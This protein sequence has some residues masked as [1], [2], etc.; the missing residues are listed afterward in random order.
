MK[1]K[2]RIVLSVLVVLLLV[3]LLGSCSGDDV[4]ALGP[5]QSD[6]D[7]AQWVGTVT[8]TDLSY[9]GEPQVEV[10]FGDGYARSITVA[11]LGFPDCGGQGSVAEG[12]LRTRLAE[13][14]PAGVAVRVVRALSYG[15]LGSSGYVFTESSVAGP[16]S[17]EPMS[18][19]AVSTSSV[20]SSSSISPTAAPRERSSEEMLVPAGSATTTRSASVSSTTA[21]RASEPVS[22]SINEVLLSEGVAVVSPSVDLS[23][24]S[25]QPVDEQVETAMGFELE[26]NDAWFTYLVDASRSA[27]DASRGSQAACR[28]TDRPRVEEKARRDAEKARQEEAQARQDAIELEKYTEDA[29]RRQA[30]REQLDAV[31]AGAD[32]QL[33]TADDDNRESAFDGDGNL[34]L[35]PTPGYSSGGSGGGGGGFVC[36]RSRLC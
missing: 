24:A 23:I 32:G 28:N 30:Q 9:D 16:S 35:V 1:S 17:P 25:D 5:R 10:D 27:W 18:S 29:A 21:G 34:Y 7:S 31:R 19:T 3:G 4:T 36:R 22:G 12:V 33:Y 14:L 13:L 20:A 6:P 15:S 26:G 8:G 2:G 11:H